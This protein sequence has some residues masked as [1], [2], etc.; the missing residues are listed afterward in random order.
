MRSE[1]KIAVVGAAGR[2]GKEIIKEVLARDGC[3]IVGAVDSPDH[4]MIGSEMPT[5][6][7]V[8][9]KR[10][11]GEIDKTPS[12][13]IDFSAPPA[14]KSTAE[15]CSE[16]GCS[17]L[18]G[19]TSLSEED[20]KAAGR[21]AERVPCLLASNFSISANVILWVLRRISSVLG[22]FDCEICEIHHRNKV[23]APSGT[24]VSMARAVAEGR[25]TSEDL[26]KAGRVGNTGVR[27]DGVIGIQSIRGGDVAGEHTVYFLG[28]GERIEISHKIS[29]RKV[30]AVGAVDAAFWLAGKEAGMYNMNDMLNLE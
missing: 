16:V 17:L 8:V 10:T 18:C 9:V 21:A 1:L 26:I 13:V 22:K 2:M 25:K 24:A 12:V 7:G 6:S 20:I 23:D 11:L 15:Y 3:S 19:S 27:S 29:S 30:F 4:P 28:Q 14:L 5:G